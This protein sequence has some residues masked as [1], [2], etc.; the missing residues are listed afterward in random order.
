MSKYTLLVL[1]NVPFVVF[2]VIKSVASYKKGKVTPFGLA[3]RLV[4]WLLVLLGLVFAEEIYNYL[5]TNGLTDSDPLSIADVV[6]V[7]GLSF[8]LFLIIRL[9]AKIETQ[10]RRFDA[11]HEKLSVSLSKHHNKGRGRG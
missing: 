11:L 1:L 2:G 5:I 9:Y 8:C 10:Q 3:A 6:L 4:F 7:T